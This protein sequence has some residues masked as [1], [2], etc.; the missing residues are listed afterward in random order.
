MAAEPDSQARLADRASQR[1]GAG[2]PLSPQLPFPLVLGSL[3]REACWRGER[4]KECSCGQAGW[5]LGKLLPQ[6]GRPKRR[7]LAPASR[8]CHAE[9][10]SQDHLGADAKG[11]P[12]DWARFCC[13][14]IIPQ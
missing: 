7:A 1:P 4:G 9:P 8:R 12:L 6:L 10:V 3:A 2:S 5:G 11:I 13:T 14:Q